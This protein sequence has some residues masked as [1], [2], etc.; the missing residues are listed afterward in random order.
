[1]KKAAWLFCALFL[2]LILPACMT[3]PSASLDGQHWKLRSVQQNSGSGE[4]VACSAEYQNSYPGAALLELSCSFTKDSIIISNGD[5]SWNGS[6]RLTNH[7][8]EA[9]MYDLDF[10]DGKNTYAVCGTTKYYDGVES[11][12]EGTLIVSSE[13]YIVY[14]VPSD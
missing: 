1:M 3:S 9:S 13:E 10:G 14:F 4:I 8:P 5:K 6:Y 11:Y 2:L 7:G 12:T